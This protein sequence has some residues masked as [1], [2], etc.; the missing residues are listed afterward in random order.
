MYIS[1]SIVAI[2]GIFAIFCI[3]VAVMLGGTVAGEPRVPAL[4][5]EFLIFAITL[6]GV[7]IFHHQTLYVSLVG[8]VSVVLMKEMFVPDF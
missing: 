3:F 5:A 8:L 6:I 1:K 7:S 4:R 2:L